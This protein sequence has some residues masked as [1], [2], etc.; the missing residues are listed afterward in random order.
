MPD[1]GVEFSGSFGA[2][3]ADAAAYV[4]HGKIRATT[5]DDITAGGGS[6]VVRPEMTRGGNLN[7]R[8]VDIVLGPGSSPFGELM[9][10]PIPPNLR[11][12]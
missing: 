12:Q 11:I 4:P 9:L 5:V 10:N 6:V 2:D 1:A 7:P 3:V 8:H